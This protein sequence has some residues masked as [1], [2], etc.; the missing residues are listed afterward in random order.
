MAEEIKKD[1]G[2]EAESGTKLVQVLHRSAR[3][4]WPAFDCDYG[5]LEAFSKS[6]DPRATARFDVWACSK[7]KACPNGYFFAPA[8]PNKPFLGSE[9]GDNSNDKHLICK[10]IFN[11]APGLTSKVT[12]EN[13]S[14]NGNRSYHIEYLN[15][16]FEDKL[17][18][19]DLLPP[20]EIIPDDVV[21]TEPLRIGEEIPKSPAKV[22]E[23]SIPSKSV[24]KEQK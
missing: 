4:S 9:P 17:V 8:D 12:P 15:P 18:M 20:S 13:V 11:G 2:T 22:A 3:I 16:R 23:L 19:E 21:I 10:I 14:R 5:H 24:D 6:I 7:S 1:Q